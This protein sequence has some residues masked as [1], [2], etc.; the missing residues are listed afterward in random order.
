MRRP[1]LLTSL[2]LALTVQASSL[3]AQTP[4][5]EAE[6]TPEQAPTEAPTELPTESAPTR[7][8]RQEDALRRQLPTEQLRQLEV[9]GDA[10]L[11]LFLPA[12]QPNP[13]GGILLIADRDEHADWPELIGPA[14]RQLSEQGWHTLAISLPDEP[15]RDLFLDEAARTETLAD[16]SE[17][18]DK[19]INA[20]AQ[21][22]NAEGA[23][24]LVLLGRGE[25]AY[26]ALH[27]TGTQASPRVEAAALILYQTRAPT[28]T[29]GGEAT[30]A[31][32][33]SQWSKPVYEVFSATQQGSRERARERNLGA[34]RHGHDLYAQLMLSKPDPSALGQSVLIKRL[35]GW[36][37]E[38]LPAQQP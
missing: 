10:F 19:R 34:Q 28:P 5:P 18:I 21:A 31:G 23:T 25:G 24:T 13:R 35:Q 27:A 22:L 12:A 37:E 30:T 2:L 3:P 1:I 32:W 36:L 29:Q 14:R 7:A 4:E 11:G 38:H 6:N 33:L 17:R 26:W 15:G 20:A 8:E 16:I 9:G